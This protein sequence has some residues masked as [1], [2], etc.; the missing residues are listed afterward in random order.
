MRF[1]YI[2]N[3]RNRVDRSVN[4][5]A[6][7]KWLYPKRDNFEIIV[8]EQL[9]MVSEKSELIQCDYHVTIHNPGAFNRSWG[10]N[11]GS[12]AAVS[13]IFIFADCDIVLKWEHLL[14]A[15]ALCES[16]IQAVD[17]KGEVLDLETSIYNPDSEPAPI[18]FS[19]RPGTV[20][21]GGICV[22]AKRAFNQIGGFDEDCRGHG[23]ED[24]IMQV[25]I[26]RMLGNT[27][28]LNFPVYHLKHVID[29]ERE[30]YQKNC[31]RLN[32]V[33]GM[34]RDSLYAMYSKRLI[35]DRDKYFL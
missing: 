24:D 21:A 30:H 16:G 3:Y 11:V 18:D 1:S 5:D 10:F 7:L 19:R 22:M 34:E 26:K 4:L 23:G 27:E 31:E 25:K 8:V 29:R 32:E 14:S 35:G 12:R 2:I 20:F 33:R 6:V 28:R 17:P 15:V 13:D 9:N